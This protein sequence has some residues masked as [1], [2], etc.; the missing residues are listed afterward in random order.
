MLRMSEGS[1]SFGDLTDGAF[2]PLIPP[3]SQSQI[4]GSPELASRRALNCYVSF[5]AIQSLAASFQDVLQSLG[6]FVA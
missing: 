2:H 4:G 1:C 3:R 6:D 5:N